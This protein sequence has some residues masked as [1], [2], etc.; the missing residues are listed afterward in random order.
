MVAVWTKEEVGYSLTGMQMRVYAYQGD[1]GK[2]LLI[3]RDCVVS[4]PQYRR[5]LNNKR[6]DECSSDAKTKCVQGYNRVR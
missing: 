4:A 2:P 6:S 1:D 5:Q 3:A